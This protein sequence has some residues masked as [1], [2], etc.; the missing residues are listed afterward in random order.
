MQNSN[1]YWWKKS[2]KELY[3]SVFQYVQH[4]RQHQNYRHENNKKY[5]KLYSNYDVLDIQQYSYFRDEAASSTQNRV[6]LN[7]VQSMVD[8]V[9]SKI[10]KNRPKPSFLTEAG[11]FSLQQKA[12]NLTQFTQ[13]QFAE[14]KF[15]AEGKRAFRDACIFGTGAVKVFPRDGAMH[16][17]RVFIDELM[18]DDN[19]SLY[20]KPRQLHQLKQIHKDVLKEMFPKAVSQIDAVGSE[21]SGESTD[22][23]VVPNNSDMIWII[24]SWHLPSSKDAADGKH[25][26]CIQNHTLMTE[27]WKKDYFPFVFWRWGERA[28]GFWGQGIAEQLQGIQLEI[29]KI[30][31]TI[32]VSMHLVSI[33]KIFLEAS[34][35][36]VT[37]H[38]DNKIGGIIRYAGTKPE[39]G[40][41]ANIPPELFSHLDR[42]Y[43]RAYEVIGI[44]EL[45]ARSSKPAGLESGRALR[46]F[47][48][49]ETERFMDVGQRYE[50]AYLDAAEIFISEIKYMVEQDSVYEDLDVK[51]QSNEFTKRIKWKDVDMDKDKY[52]LFLHP[53]SSLSSTPAGKLQDVQELLQAGFISAEEGRDLLDFPDLKGYYNY[54]NS[55]IEDIKRSIELIVDEGKYYSPEPYQDLEMGITKMQ[56]AY[57]YYRT[58][59][60]PESKLELFRRW[61]EDAQVLLKKAAEPSEEELVQQQLNAQAGQSLDA[62]PVTTPEAVLPPVPAPGV[63]TE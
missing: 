55:P 43:Q 16:A 13:G 12:K 59:D 14:T 3:K 4:L 33:P 5:L 45:S 38:L 31:R 40:P 41:L 30:L 63:P 51:V 34:S 49:I 21:L 22:F 18:V 46:E 8:T 57:L 35:K 10:G 20:G 39:N 23:G 28:M 50:Q 60:L 58:R 62:Q 29:N 24:E 37:A 56:Q 36:V 48:D 44:S 27:D 17:E 2:D 26:I 47:N 42:L 11:D 52:S 6:T 9:V 19:E 25:A 61:I 54:A 32:Q 7:V 1:Y 53:T 15:Y